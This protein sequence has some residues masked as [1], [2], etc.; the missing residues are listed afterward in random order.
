MVEWYYVLHKCF[1]EKSD[2]NRPFL[3]KP[4]IKT[5]CLYSRCMK[6]KTSVMS[7]INQCN[8]WFKT[9]NMFIKT[10][11][12][13]S[14]AILLSSSARFTLMSSNSAECSAE[15]LPELQNS[16]SIY[17]LQQ[18]LTNTT[19]GFC[20]TSLLL[21]SNSGL[22]VTLGNLWGCQTFNRPNARPLHKQ[23]T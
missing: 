7:K 17:P 11:L 8:H 19:V 10:N 2:V 9:K 21:W 13:P 18:A 3:Q 16:R 5:A 14:F 6:T 1:P 15:T 23:A 4:K 20:L 12:W 22:W